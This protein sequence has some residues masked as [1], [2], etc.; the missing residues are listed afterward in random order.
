MRKTVSLLAVLLTLCLLFSSASCD[1]ATS[2]NNSVNTHESIY[3][4]I[5]TSSSSRT[6]TYV[7]NKRSKKIHKLDCGTG[8][9]IDPKNRSTYTGSIDDLLQNGYTTCG[10]CFRS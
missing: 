1:N 6:T 5:T 8:D 10:N 2:E 9:L 7:L 3:S 4:E